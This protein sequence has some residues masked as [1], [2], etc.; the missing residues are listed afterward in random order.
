MSNIGVHH[1]VSLSNLSFV[2]FCSVS[3]YL[4]IRRPKTHITI[5]HQGGHVA[6]LPP[7]IITRHDNQQTLPHLS[8]S[9]FSLISLIL[10]FTRS[11]IATPSTTPPM[12][13]TSQLIAQIILRQMCIHKKG[14]TYNHP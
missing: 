7:S 6:T 14:R 1:S 3:S 8:D 4:Y 10:M 9:P 12:M 2:Y 13:T 5:W 11:A